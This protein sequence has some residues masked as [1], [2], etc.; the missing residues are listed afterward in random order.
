MWRELKLKRKLSP[1]MLPYHT[2]SRP[3]CL[4]N[5]EMLSQNRENRTE[6]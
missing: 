4:L 1:K 5:E 2:G 6:V 3:V